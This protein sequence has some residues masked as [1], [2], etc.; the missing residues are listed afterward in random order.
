MPYTFR[1]SHCGFTSNASRCERCHQPTLHP[2]WV[3]FGLN[4]QVFQAQLQ[5]YRIL[6]KRLAP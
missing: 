1:C 4:Q 5:A 2:K 6:Y 3:Q